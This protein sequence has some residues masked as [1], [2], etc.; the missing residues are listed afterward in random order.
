MVQG[1]S[2]WGGQGSEAVELQQQPDLNPEQPVFMS[3]VVYRKSCTEV[4]RVSL[5][6]KQRVLANGMSQCCTAGVRCGHEL[7]DFHSL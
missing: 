1:K 4:G 7:L 6:H 2:D 3:V 5:P